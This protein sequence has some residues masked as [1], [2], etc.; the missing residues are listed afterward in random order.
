MVLME[1]EDCDAVELQCIIQ[2]G[3]S[4]TA[5]PITQFAYIIDRYWPIADM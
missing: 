5:T 2:R 1:E 4:V 3:V